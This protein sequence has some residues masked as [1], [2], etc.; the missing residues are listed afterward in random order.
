MTIRLLPE[1]L[2]SLVR[3]AVAGSAGNVV[4]SLVYLALAQSSDAVTVPSVVAST[5][6]TLAVGEAHRWW[7]FRGPG[8]PTLLQA[9]ASGLASAL[10]GTSLTAVVLLVRT[11]LFP[12]AS[13]AWDLALS[14]SVTGVVGAGSFLHL[15]RAARGRRGA[16]AVVASSGQVMPTLPPVA[17]SATS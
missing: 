2:R 1:G 17:A 8:R 10:L 11:W 3:F 16:Q 4:Y 15:R 13:V 5:V 9:H 7:T 6:S 12:D 14:W